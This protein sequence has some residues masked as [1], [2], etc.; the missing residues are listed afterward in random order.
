MSGHS[1]S[2]KQLFLKAIPPQSWTAVFKD[3]LGWRMPQ[4]KR[5]KRR[6]A[7]PFLSQALIARRP[8]NSLPKCRPRLIEHPAKPHRGDARSK[9]ACRIDF[10]CHR[11]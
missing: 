1:C 2:L 7:A 5:G 3:L 6:F 10:E 4:F 9:P 11:A 8:K